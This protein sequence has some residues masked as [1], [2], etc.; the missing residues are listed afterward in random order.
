MA[1]RQRSRAVRHVVIR[2][3][4]DALAGAL[5][6]P[7]LESGHLGI[8]PS[9]FTM[10]SFSS[11]EFVNEFLRKHPWMELGFLDGYLREMED[12]CSKSLRSSVH[13]NYLTFIQTSQKL[14][15][16][17][18]DLGMVEARLNEL[19]MTV[20]KLQEV[21]LKGSTKKTVA[22][23]TVSD[24]LSRHSSLDGGFPLGDIEEEERLRDMSVD[25]LRVE[26]RW[27]HDGV[28]PV[29]KWL[30]N[31]PDELDVLITRRKFAEAL[32][33][34]EK[35]YIDLHGAPPS[36]KQEILSREALISRLLLEDMRNPSGYVPEMTKAVEYLNRLGRG[37]L[38]RQ[39]FLRSR[40]KRIKLDIRRLNFQGDII[41]H[42]EEVSY[43]VF[44]HIR[45]TSRDYGT[46]FPIKKDVGPFVLWAVSELESFVNILRLQLFLG[47]ELETIT[48]T[49]QV[50]YA[51]CNTLQ[52][53]GLSLTHHLELLFLP[54]V[55]RVINDEIGAIRSKMDASVASDDWKAKERVLH[56]EGGTEEFGP[57]DEDESTS[58]ADDRARSHKSVTVKLTDSA[59]NFYAYVHKFVSDVVFIPSPELYTIVVDALVGFFE[60]Y[61]E[62][63]LGPK[64][65]KTKLNTEIYLSLVCNAHYILVDLIPRVMEELKRQFQRPIRKMESFLEQYD[66]FDML[67]I[68]TIVHHKAAGV[69][70][71]RLLWCDPAYP[72]RRGTIEAVG[73][74]PVLPFE[75][76]Y[77]F[78]AKFVNAAAGYLPIPLV[79]HVLGSLVDNLAFQL[80]EKGTIWNLLGSHQDSSA[81]ASE[82]TGSTERLAED[83]EGH[84]LSLPPMTPFCIHQCL[85]DLHFFRHCV[86]NFFSQEA[87]EKL[88]FAIVSIREQYK[89]LDPTGSAELFPSQWY[90]NIALTSFESPSLSPFRNILAKILRAAERQDGG[91]GF[92]GRPQ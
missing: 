1:S 31:V 6:E 70:R 73:A 72:P 16:I 18:N 75:Q 30:L 34:L 91:R 26:R 24:G 32:D 44:S 68:D 38:A 10:E 45:V 50:V 59:K 49:L 17:E 33:V 42:G 3:P 43:L 54:D 88:D 57:D 23:S 53:I 25:Q 77:H 13:H 55:T 90:E 19:S 11:K 60:S 37:E 61:F 48:R 27:L 12:T 83:E 56:L 29:W 64:A 52:N 63:V 62:D 76:L 2:E 82:R 85:V 5:S 8:S 20:H 51:N 4:P 14:S 15:M 40:S 46:M 78:V 71:S 69:V 67:L 81:G 36:L 35:A 92:A 21:K 66:D 22:P 65:T 80:C 74:S 28:D 47:S 7:H 79:L 58:A 86:L 41:A 89:A 9:E 87:R 39:M 84:K